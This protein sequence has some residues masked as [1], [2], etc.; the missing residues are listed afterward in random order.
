MEKQERFIHFNRET[1]LIPLEEVI[2]KKF[3]TP[4]NNFQVFQLD[5]VENGIP[6]IKTPT[7]EPPYLGPEGFSVTHPHLW[8][9]EDMMVNCLSPNFS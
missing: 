2:N 7:H 9:P 5:R 6:Y 3:G 4:L 8:A 1:Y